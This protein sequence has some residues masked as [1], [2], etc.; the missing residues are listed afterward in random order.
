MHGPGTVSTRD[1]ILALLAVVA[2]AVLFFG[3]IVAGRDPLIWP[4]FEKLVWPRTGGAAVPKQGE[5]VDR[6]Q[7]SER[8]AT[9]HQHTACRPSIQGRGSIGAVHGR[10]AS[11]PPVTAFAGAGRH[12]VLQSF[13]ADRLLDPPALPALPELD[14]MGRLSL[15]P[16]DRLASDGRRQ[17]EDLAT[18]RPACDP[19]SET[20]GFTPAEPI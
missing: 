13:P 17:D 15:A 2:I 1:R 9:H 11:Q 7:S 5:Q 4:D 10:V 19:S 14:R 12:T 18:A 3:H 16:G 20:A 8:A 6:K